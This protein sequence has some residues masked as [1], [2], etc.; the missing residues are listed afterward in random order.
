MNHVKC[1]YCDVV[2][3][4]DHLFQHLLTHRATILS[5]MPK[6][7]LEARIKE[8]SPYVY[9]KHTNGTF[10]FIVCLHCHKGLQ[11]NSRK[12]SI[13]SFIERYSSEHKD[14]RNN[15]N[16]YQCLFQCESVPTKRVFNFEKT[17]TSPK[18]ITGPI[19]TPPTGV[20]EEFKTLFKQW[21]YLKEYGNLNG[22]N[23]EDEEYDLDF[24]KD[25]MQEEIR[26]ADKDAESVDS[27]ADYYKE[28]LESIRD[29][30]ITKP[31]EYTE[32][33]REILDIIDG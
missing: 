18:P 7:G 13:K 28:K 26:N 1:P 31:F 14:C 20:D 30:T 15:F 6:A 4:S 29:I 24:V 5:E 33:A 3:R 17:S 19:P 11:C 8:C 12:S 10:A 25:K 23:E 16:K 2:K 9:G 22:Y 27:K 21:S 32:E